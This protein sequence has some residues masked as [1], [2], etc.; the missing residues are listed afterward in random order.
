MDFIVLLKETAVDC[1]VISRN[2]ADGRDGY[3]AD[4]MT[5]AIY[6]HHQKTIICDAEIKG[7]KIS[8]ANY[9]FNMSFKK[10]SKY[11]KFGYSEKATKFEKIFHLKFP[12]L[13]GQKYASIF[14][15]NK[16]KGICFWDFLI[17]KGEQSKR[18]IV[19]FIGGLDITDGRYDS[20]EF[21]L[22]KTLKTLHKGDFY[23]LVWYCLFFKTTVKSATVD[24]AI[25]ITKTDFLEQNHF[26]NHS[27]YLIE[28]SKGHK[29]IFSWKSIAQ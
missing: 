10:W 15:E 16:N 22:F 23:R 6:T 26:T 21:P 19:A 7:Q 27:S 12:L 11:L 4:L 28:G 2:R 9:L 5:G 24:H 29:S 17:F 14:A 1:V 25:F 13:L 3:K 8:E 18:Q 20:P